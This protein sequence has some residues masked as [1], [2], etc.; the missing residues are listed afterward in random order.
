MKRKD[1]RE[2]ELE[3]EVAR[4]ESELASLRDSTRAPESEFGRRTDLLREA[5]RV[6]HLGSWAWDLRTGEIEWS[7]EFHRILGVDPRTVKPSS[8]AFF[9]AV[10][11]DDRAEVRRE[12]L[13]QIET[14][15]IRSIEFRIVRPSGETRDL[16]MEAGFTYDDGRLVH[17]IGTVLDI[18]LWRE[19]EVL[20]ARTVADLNE[21]QR[22]AGVGSWRVDHGTQRVEW[23]EGM[24][25]L[26]D[27]SRNERP[28]DALLLGRLHPADRRAFT[29]L[30]EKPAECRVLRSDGSVR[31]MLVSAHAQVDAS[32][33]LTGLRGIMQDITERKQLEE[34][35]R[36]SQKMEAV[37]ALAGGVAHD[38]N[39]YLT[40]VMGHAAM[41]QDG[42]DPG[43]D[44][45]DSAA[46]IMDVVDQCAR[47]TRQLLMFSRRGSGEPRH[48]D[49]SAL[50]LRLEPMLRAMM[51]ETIR[52]TCE[53]ERPAVV[54]ADPTQLEQVLLNLCINAKEAMPRGGSLRVCV[55][56]VILDDAQSGAAVSLSVR[57]TGCGIPDALRARIFEP[58]F[59][60]KGVG[61]GTGLGLATVYGIVR[62]AGG[63]VAVE[64]SVG[65]GS[66]FRVS[67]PPGD[68]AQLIT[69][70]GHA[71][72]RALAGQKVVLV[73]IEIAYVRALLMRHLE[74]AGFRVLGADDGLEAIDLIEETQVDLVV[75][76]LPLGNPGAIELA[77]V[78][79]GRRAAIRTL[80]MTSYASDAF[81]V[82][83]EPGRRTLRKPIPMG[84]LLEAVR[85]LAG[86]STTRSY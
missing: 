86:S 21:A 14:G 55:D 82:R 80:A 29:E 64:S 65:V 44:A 52:L 81:E 7:E 4:L 49:L 33:A 47:L 66:E 70:R 35:L 37:G 75:T 67:L 79:R 13:R 56:S 51:G 69:F 38:F 8:E 54:C 40:I 34:Q 57:D 42:L 61:I 45:H 2:A 23:S 27:V 20:L 19:T 50:V 71:G 36:Y 31:T 41:L 24:Y 73:V 5:E 9:G 18:T 83:D 12:T 58:F 1:T 11:E 10:H 62:D 53:V 22:M 59:T 25:R 6:A 30:A 78:L 48:L 16:R 15:E 43:S 76:D 85:Q 28:S 32:G 39:N 84:D 46:A 77:Q 60:T 74:F 17:V 3:A 26:L 63:K 68:T 72:G